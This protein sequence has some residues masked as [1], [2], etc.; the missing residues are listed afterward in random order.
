[1]DRPSWAEERLSTDR[2]R[3]TEELNGSI[4]DLESGFSQNDAYCT[5]VSRLMRCASNDMM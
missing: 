5:L 1:M 2:Q 3:L 4:H